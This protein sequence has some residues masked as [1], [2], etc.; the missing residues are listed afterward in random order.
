M[1]PFILQSK[2]TVLGKEIGLLSNPEL[3]GAMWISKLS[4]MFSIK[5]F[6]IGVCIRFKR[7]LFGDWRLAALRNF[8]QYSILNEG[9]LFSQEMS[10]QKLQKAHHTICS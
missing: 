1:I 5:G 8:R 6:D 7:D 4:K 9:S 10:N 2:S 3:R